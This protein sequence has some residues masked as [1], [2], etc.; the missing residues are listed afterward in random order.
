MQYNTTGAADPDLYTQLL[1][2]RYGPLSALLA[3]QRRPSR[4]GPPQGT[5]GGRRAFRLTPTSPEQAR[6]HLAELA[7]EIGARHYHPESHAA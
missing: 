3:E 5:D 4:P 1:E 2:E 6:L 7:D